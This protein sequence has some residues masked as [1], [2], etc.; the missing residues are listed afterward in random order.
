MLLMVAVAFF[1][2]PGVAL[3]MVHALNVA[4]PFTARLL[5]EVCDET[6]FRDLSN[7]APLARSFFP[8]HLHELVYTTPEQYT[9]LIKTRPSPTITVDSNLTIS[10][11]GEWVHRWRAHNSD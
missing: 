6:A 8:K 2:S 9:S 11:A 7:H 4:T 1:Y 3:R 10:F 5:D